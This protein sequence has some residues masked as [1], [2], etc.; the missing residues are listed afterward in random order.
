M[1]EQLGY[2]HI[3]LGKGIGSEENWKDLKFPCQ[4]NSWYRDSLSN[5]LKKNNNDDKHQTIR[6][7]E[8]LISSV[9]TLLDLCPVFNE[10]SRR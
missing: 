6:K 4:A 10:N 7:G 5:N 9:I 2:D 3:C 8:N 1:Q